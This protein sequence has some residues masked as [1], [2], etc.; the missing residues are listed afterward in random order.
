MTPDENYIPKKSE[1]PELKTTEV[2]P[3]VTGYPQ[4]TDREI[5]DTLPDLPAME[6]LPDPDALPDPGYP[7]MPTTAR[8]Y[9]SGTVESPPGSW[10]ADGPGAHACHP[11]WPPNPPQ[12]SFHP[13]E[14]DP[15]AQANPDQSPQ[16]SH[17]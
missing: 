3:F 5:D 13:V 12:P 6:Q 11:E 9:A 8:D 15:P 16:L 2:Y 4:G 10:P 14:P 7:V 17:S 1:E